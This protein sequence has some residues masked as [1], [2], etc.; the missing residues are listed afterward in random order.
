MGEK[1][2]VNPN[3]NIKVKQI[4]TE[5]NIH[6]N[7]VKPKVKKYTIKTNKLSSIHLIRCSGYS[8]FLALDNKEALH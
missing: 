4:F 1:K 6:V 7:S 3:S 5:T 2:I 8:L